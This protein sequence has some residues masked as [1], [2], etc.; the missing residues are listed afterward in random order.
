MLCKLQVLYP[1]K[2]LCNGHFYQ[3]G[4]ILATN[5]DVASFRF[6]TCAMTLGARGLASVAGQHH[7][8]LNLV[9]PLTEHL[10]E[11]IYAEQSPFLFLRSKF[12]FI[13]NL[14]AI[15]A[16]GLVLNR[17]SVPKPVLLVLRQ[18]KVR[19]KDRKT[20]F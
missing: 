8:V 10:K 18:L 12:P 14:N 6:Q 11:L 13:W 1:R 20:A 16:L 15:F 5:F 2:Q 19:L 3:F 17:T 4:N 7:T 9:L